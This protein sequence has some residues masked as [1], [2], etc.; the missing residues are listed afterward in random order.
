MKKLFKFLW[1]WLVILVL[2]CTFIS[3]FSSFIPP[4]YFWGFFFFSYSAPFMIGINAALLLLYLFI[5]KRFWLIAISMALSIYGVANNWSLGGSENDGTAN[6]SLLSYNVRVFDLYNW[7][8]GK[9]WDGWKPRTDNGAT[10]DSLYSTIIGSNADF[11]CFQE[12]Y[13]QK[14]GDYE[15]VKYFSEHGYG[16]S[17]ITYSFEDDNN[18]YG[19]ATFS[20][21]PIVNRETVFFKENSPKSGPQVTDIKMG[22]DTIRIINVHMK[23]YKLGRSD[24]QYLNRLSD[25]TLH[26]FDSK[27]T[28]EL[29]KKIRIA[30]IKR[31]TQ[32][33]ELL[34][35]LD[36]SPHQTL[37]CGDFNEVP[38]SYFYRTISGRLSDSFLEVG[39]GFGTTL[40]SRLPAIRIDYVFHSSNIKAVSH[41]IIQREL[42]DHYPVL[43]EFKSNSSV[44]E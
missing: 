22:S 7:L 12:F 37:L 26:R 30:F 31:A 19:L 15:T 2:T 1:K 21:Y 33:D 17:H 43:F 13:N 28:K 16:Y 34:T 27:P 18:Q 38:N 24:Y 25:S 29:F 5:K 36:N 23:S 8:D 10:L 11:L 40:I 9:K 4:K 20:K 41:T 14:N 42:S 32:L 39:S 44:I 3:V 6:Y 35:V